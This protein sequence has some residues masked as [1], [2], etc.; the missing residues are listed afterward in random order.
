[1]YFSS[2]KPIF[3][4]RLTEFHALI[5]FESR[6]PLAEFF[7]FFL[8]RKIDN[9]F[10]HAKVPNCSPHAPANL[11][12][13]CVKRKMSSDENLYELS[14]RPQS[15]YAPFPR[16]RTPYPSPFVVHPHCPYRDQLYYMRQYAPFYYDWLPEE[17]ELSRMVSW[18]NSC[19]DLLVVQ[20]NDGGIS[21]LKSVHLLPLVIMWKGHL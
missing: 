18:R 2:I 4:K 15:E 16:W 3:K 19:I 5:L 12:S 11:L 10:Y 21:P 20:S 6:K 7:S 8:L 9:L 13:V 1:M 17:D 14:R